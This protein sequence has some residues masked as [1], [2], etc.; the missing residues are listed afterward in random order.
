MIAAVGSHKA[1]NLRAFAVHLHLRNDLASGW[2]CNN[3]P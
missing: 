3:V 2:H 1:I